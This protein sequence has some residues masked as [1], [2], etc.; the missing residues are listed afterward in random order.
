MSPLGEK[1]IYLIIN[2][3]GM[4]QIAFIK[5]LE[6]Q[7][8]ELNITII[9]TWTEITNIHDQSFIRPHLLFNY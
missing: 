2:L 1:I 8:V 3:A 5:V 4:N 7:W 9:S 6:D